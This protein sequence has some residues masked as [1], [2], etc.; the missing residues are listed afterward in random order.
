V[1]EDYV[2]LVDKTY[3]PVG[4]KARTGKAVENINQDDDGDD[5]PP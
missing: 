5:I 3:L 4:A 1:P 2:V